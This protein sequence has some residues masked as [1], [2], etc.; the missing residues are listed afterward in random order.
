MGTL[1]G[2]ILTWVDNDVLSFSAFTGL[3]SC[4][5]LCLS[6]VSQFIFVSMFPY[7]MSLYTCTFFPD[8]HFYSY[9]VTSIYYVKLIVLCSI[10][11]F[12]MTLCMDRP[13]CACAELD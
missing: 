11:V 5:I 8:A 7:L 3:P 4:C 12:H 6:L 10:I 1:E 9:C 2:Q 13:D